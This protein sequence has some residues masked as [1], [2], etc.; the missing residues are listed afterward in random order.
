MQYRY[1]PKQK[2]I[3]EEEGKIRDRSRQGTY[4]FLSSRFRVHR[5]Y[6]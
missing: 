5:R 2:I 1:G 4:S 6:H 3:D